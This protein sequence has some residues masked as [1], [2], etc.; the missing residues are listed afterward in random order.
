MTIAAGF[1][2]SDGI[3]LASD[4]LYSQ[5]GMGKKYGPKFWILDHG[6]VCVVFGG[7]GTASGLLRTRDEINRKLKPGL[8]RIRVMDTIDGALA[9]VHSKVPSVEFKTDALVAVRTNDAPDCLYEN[10]ATEMWSRIEEPCE[11][12]GDGQSLG[13]YFL[14]ALFRADVPLRW[15]KVVAAHAIKQCKDYSEFCGG[16]THFIELPTGG[17]PRFIDDQ[18]EI[19]DY[20]Q[21]LAKID[22]AMRVVLPDGRANDDTLIDRVERITEAIE[23][24]SKKF[25]IKLK[26]GSVGISGGLVATKIT[27][28]PNDQKKDG[29]D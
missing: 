12:V 25:T 8:S 7:A 6:D 15:A 16:D 9:K 26:A 22:R 13:W 27:Q 21:H 14:S 10:F 23:E 29:E 24:A 28:P 2:C 18:S 5:T 19:A 20:E 1:V 3:L 4:T 11:C 17:S